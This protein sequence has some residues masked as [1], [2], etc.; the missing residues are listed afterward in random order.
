[1]TRF[2]SEDVEREAMRM[3]AVMMASSVRTAPKARGID[4]IK[5]MIVDGSDLE[6]LASAMEGKAKERPL[7]LSSAFTR[8]AQNVRDSGCVLLIGVM[9][10]PKRAEQPLD[11]GACGYK[12][13]KDLLNAG[14]RQGKDFNGPNCILQAMDLG[15]A[16]GSAVV[17]LEFSPT[18]KYFISGSRD[19][20]VSVF[21]RAGEIIKTFRAYGDDEVHVAFSRNGKKIIAG[22]RDKKAQA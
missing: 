8:D 11:C 2:K 6:L 4:D 15:I 10:N 20:R 7:Y 3:V 16:L 1:M 5:T 17:D 19:G 18:G 13:C 12:S 22:Y 14:R 9:G 21:T